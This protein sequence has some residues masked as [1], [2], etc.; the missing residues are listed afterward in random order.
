MLL[1]QNSDY[2]FI[3]C[4]VLSIYMI[5]SWINSIRMLTKFYETDAS[6]LELGYFLPVCKLNAVLPVSWRQVTSSRQKPFFSFS[7]TAVHPFM[8]SVIHRMVIQRHPAWEC[9][10]QCTLPSITIVSCSFLYI[11]DDPCSPD[12]SRVVCNTWISDFYHGW[13][14]SSGILGMG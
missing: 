8:Q 11:L 12:I 3:F 4:I 13:Y 2:S 5:S 1:L 7:R 6:E 10:V 9:P 14:I